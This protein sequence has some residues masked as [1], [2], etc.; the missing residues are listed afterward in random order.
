MGEKIQI[1]MIILENLRL[2]KMVTKDFSLIYLLVKNETVMKMVSG[3]AMNREEAKDKFAKILEANALHPEM[4]YFKITNYGSEFIG[5][6][7]IELKEK[8][9]KEAELGYLILPEF[10][11]KGIA[12][13]VA[14]KLV[15][16]ARNGKQLNSLYAIIDPDNM[17]SR[18]ILEKN[19]FTSK[20]LKDFDGLPGE[21]LELDLLTHR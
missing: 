21:L 15:E 2:E 12:G 14:K 10:W 8:K 9:S 18:K 16:I 11:R 5:V 7:K 20:E 13:K 4:G 3:K 19:G 1:I 17:P 6:A